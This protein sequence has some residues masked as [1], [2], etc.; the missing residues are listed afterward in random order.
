M[1]LSLIDRGPRG[2]IDHEVVTGHGGKTGAGI[3]DVQ[4]VAVY[5]CH[6][7]SAR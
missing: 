4:F 1:G 2:D 5:G 7:V 3:A 6:F